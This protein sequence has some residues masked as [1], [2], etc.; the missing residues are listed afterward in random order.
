MSN[1]RQ[2]IASVLCEARE[3]SHRD[4][5]FD[6]CRD[7]LDHADRLLDEDERVAELLAA[8]GQATNGR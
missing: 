7:C 3:P 2:R 6:Y 8:I 1:A 4:L 5:D